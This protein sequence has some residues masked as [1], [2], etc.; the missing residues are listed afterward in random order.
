MNRQLLPLAIG[1]SCRA[2]ASTAGMP[3]RS[4]RGRGQQ[5]PTSSQLAHAP[6]MFEP[7][8]T[9]FA[10]HWPRR[11]GQFSQKDAGWLGGLSRA[12]L[13]SLFQSTTI[14]VLEQVLA[15]SQARHDVLAGNIANLNTPGYQVRDLSVD[16]FQDL[17]EKAID[18]RPESP[19]IQSRSLNLQ[20]AVE[21]DER[22]RK[23]KDSLP[24]ILMHDGS[25]VGLEQQV[26]ELSK[27]QMMHNMAISIMSSQ[28]RMLQAA[29]S[30][31][32]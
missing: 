15:F 24:S 26:A 29:I 19:G 28:F 27:N 6:A 17:L 20:Q 4:H 18:A 13:G 25:N 16:A 3:R 2:Y 8:G 12:M 31:R 5:L 32:V 21:R 22:L 7:S 23:V 14:P 30:E 1:K 9:L 10:Y 11:I